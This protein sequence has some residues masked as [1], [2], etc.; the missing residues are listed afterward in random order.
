MTAPT[1]EQLADAS[2][3]GWL[4]GFNGRPPPELHETLVDAYADGRRLGT[5]RSGRLPP[6]RASLFDTDYCRAVLAWSPYDSCPR[7]EASQ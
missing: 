3:R 2:A 5:A 7:P 6:P 1:P 4:D